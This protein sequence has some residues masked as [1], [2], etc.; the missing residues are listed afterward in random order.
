ME[1]VVVHLTRDPLDQYPIGSAS[2]PVAVFERY[3]V[4]GGS[5]CAAIVVSFKSLQCE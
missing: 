4:C 3:L 5:D 2:Y 1:C